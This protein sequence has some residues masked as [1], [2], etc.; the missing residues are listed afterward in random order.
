MKHSSL[1]PEKQNNFYISPEKALP[2][3]WDDCPSSCKIKNP[4]YSKMTAD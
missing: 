3:F 2:T 1:K 4:S